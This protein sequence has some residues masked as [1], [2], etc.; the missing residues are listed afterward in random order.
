MPRCTFTATSRPV[1]GSCR[2]PRQSCPVGRLQQQ[3]GRAGTREIAERAPVDNQQ[4][5]PQRAPSA[6]ALRTPSHAWGTGRGAVAGC[7]MRV[8]NSC[9]D[10]DTHVVCGWGQ[11][12]LTLS[13]GARRLYRSLP[14]FGSLVISPLSHSPHADNPSG[15]NTGGTDLRAAGPLST[16]RTL[17]AVRLGDQPLPGGETL[18]ARS[19]GCVRSSVPSRLSTCISHVRTSQGVSDPINSCA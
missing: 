3:T 14:L 11:R 4:A 12:L 5:V 7:K 18:H 16:A 6:S 15:F 1:A 17:K 2:A 13:F 19:Y 9:Q 10:T 8:V